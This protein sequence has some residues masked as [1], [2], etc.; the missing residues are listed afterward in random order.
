MS[1]YTRAKISARKLTAVLTAAILTIA[2]LVGGVFAYTDFS[3]D[4]IN[5]FRGGNDNDIL[6]HDDFEPGVNKDVYVENTG[7][8]EMIVRVKFTEYLQIGNTPIVGTDPNDKS[9]WETHL[10]GETSPATE[11]CTLETHD[12]FT[13]VMSGGTKVYKPGTGEAG[14]D[15]FTVGQ[16]FEDG[17]IAKNTLPAN[18]PISMAEYMANRETYDAEVNGRWILDV[19]GYAYWSKLLQPHTATNLLLDNVITAVKPDDNYYYAI[20][21]ILEGANK[22]EAYKLIDRGATDDGEDLI[23]GLDGDEENSF[24]PLLRI[25][26]ALGTDGQGAVFS[27]PAYQEGEDYYV[28]WGDG[29]EPEHNGV[30]HRYARDGVYDISIGG[31]IQSEEASFQDASR[32]IA[33]LGPLPAASGT[34]FGIYTFANCLNLEYISP[35]VFANNPQITEFRYTFMGCS[36]L[37][38]IPEELFSVHAQALKFS[39]TFFMCTKLTAIPDRLFYANTAVTSFADV[40]RGCTALLSIPEALFANNT[41]AESF[42]HSFYF[43][44]SLQSIPATLFEFNLL[45]IDFNFC[46]NGCGSVQGELPELW[47]SH[48]NAA[49]H[50][51]VFGGCSL[52]DNYST[53]HA[54]GWV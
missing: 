30:T 38:E 40:F 5:R 32:L 18:V 39:G 37:T 20:D 49:G 19:D 23:D 53:A 10:F 15:S 7:E 25:N 45:P 8:T 9:T 16:D 17:A 13:W 24:S 48:A 51:N 44:S 21:V 14:N 34:D 36:A 2:L 3:Q 11:N 42:N 43:C 47:L 28:D 26:T 1:R 27:L 41:M 31:S 22:T 12:Y 52:A 35:D 6:L 46:F 33:V 29:S 50:V 54:E 4:F